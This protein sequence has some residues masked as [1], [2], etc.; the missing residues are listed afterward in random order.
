GARDRVVADVIRQAADRLARARRLSTAQR[1]AAVRGA[2]SSPATGTV[3]PAVERCACLDGGRGR[4][5]AVHDLAEV[6]LSDWTAEGQ[7][8]AQVVQSQDDQAVLDYLRARVEDACGTAAAPTARDTAVPCLMTLALS[9]SRP[10]HMVAIAREP[11]VALL[12][13]PG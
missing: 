11:I 12:A 13:A 1:Q 7:D 9:R 5:T 2:V 10:S 3:L 6:A 4:L 8:P